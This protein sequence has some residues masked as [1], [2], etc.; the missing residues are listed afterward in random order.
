[1]SKIR[2][3]V[4]DKVVVVTATY[5]NGKEVDG[6]ILDKLRHRLLDPTD[7]LQTIEG[8]DNTI[9]GLEL[10]KIR[11]AEKLDELGAAYDRLYENFE[12][13]Q[14]LIKEYEELTLSYEELVSGH[15]K[16][17]GVLLTVT[18]A[19]IVITSVLFSVLV[20]GGLN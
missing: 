20:Y 5:R 16:K 12:K 10:E 4:D 17:Y 14:E 11:M 3:E 7:N 19:S 13:K 15:Y 18:L 1:M 2:T 6:A 8:M 9:S